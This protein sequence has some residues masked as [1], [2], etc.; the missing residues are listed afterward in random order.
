MNC[1]AGRRPRIERQR[2]LIREFALGDEPMLR[3]VFLSAVHTRTA[4]FYSPAEGD[5][6]APRISDE[7]P[8]FAAVAALRPFVA[9]VDGRV[10][11]YADLQT[12]GLIDHFFVAAEYTRRGVG[13]ALM[14][15]IGDAASRR[16][17]G[18]LAAF[19]SL[20][21]ESFFSAHGFVLSRRQVVVRNGVALRNALMVRSLPR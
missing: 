3:A 2:I 14:Q 16:G 19:V 18:E 15:H 6:W 17:I 10:A 7:R 5:A 12:S 11:G 1:C 8:W 21:A 9:L 13:S 20:A 4:D